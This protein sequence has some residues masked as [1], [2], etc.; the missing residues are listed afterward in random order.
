M[1]ERLLFTSN[2]TFY[3]DGLLEEVV[4][5]LGVKCSDVCM[6]KMEGGLGVTTRN[7]VFFSDKCRC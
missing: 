1:S 6:P 4:K 7:I 2:I 5:F 3:G